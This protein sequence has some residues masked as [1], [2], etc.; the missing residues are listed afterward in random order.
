MNV[1]SLRE[2]LNNHP[3]IVSIQKLKKPGI[4][5]KEHKGGRKEVFRYNINYHTD[6]PYNQKL[7]LNRSEL[8]LTR[9]INDLAN[10]LIYNIDAIK[11]SFKDHL[12]YESV[13]FF[14]EPLL[15]PYSDHIEMIFTSFEKT[16]TNSVIKLMEFY[17]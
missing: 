2:I 5:I 17:D 13:I 8:L 11:R 15:S 12:G 10:L 4:Y 9:N 14:S 16:K 6:K 1:N 7:I 3:D